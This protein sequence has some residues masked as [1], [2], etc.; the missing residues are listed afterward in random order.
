[1]WMHVKSKTPISTT[2]LIIVEPTGENFNQIYLIVTVFSNWLWRLFGSI[3]YL[4]LVVSFRNSPAFWGK[5]SNPTKN[6]IG[7]RYSPFKVYIGMKTWLWWSVHY[8]QF[9]WCMHLAYKPPYFWCSS[10]TVANLFMYISVASCVVLFPF[11]HKEKTWFTFKYLDY[12][13]KRSLFCLRSTG[14][15][16]GWWRR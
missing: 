11:F 5:D 14:W 7:E 8:L 10:F 15:S 13:D 16:C 3:E 1:M 6:W 12:C 2:L 4:H 9:R